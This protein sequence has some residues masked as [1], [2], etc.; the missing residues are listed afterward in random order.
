MADEP[1]PTVESL[2]AEI[3]ALKEREA[4]KEDVGEE[5]KKKEEALKEL[6]EKAAAE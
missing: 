5:L 6:E 3:A 2:K 1:Q 4:N